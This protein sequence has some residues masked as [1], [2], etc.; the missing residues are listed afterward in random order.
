[1]RDLLAPASVERLGVLDPAEVGRVVG[2]HLAGRASFGFELWG[3]AVL[4]A[5][6]RVRV[7][8]RPAAPPCRDLRQ[9]H[10][11]ERSGEAA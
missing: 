11:G 4:V 1:L 10:I 3:L 8:R 6:H 9:L 2:D 5:W 7:E